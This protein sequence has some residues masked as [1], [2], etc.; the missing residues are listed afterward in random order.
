MAVRVQCMSCSA[1]LKAPEHLIGTTVACPKCKQQVQVVAAAAQGQ[2]NPANALD[3]LAALASQNPNVAPAGSPNLGFPQ[4]PG[5]PGVGAS[6]GG[7]SQPRK[8]KS[9]KGLWIALGSV[10]AV[11]IVAVVVVAL[12]PS[13]EDDTPR[14]E[15]AAN[16]ADE[17]GFR[18]GDVVSFLDGVTPVRGVYEYSVSGHLARI[19]FFDH[20]RNSEVARDV[21]KSLLTHALDTEIPDGISM[22]FLTMPMGGPFVPDRLQ[23]VNLSEPIYVRVPT[24]HREID[25]SGYARLFLSSDRSIATVTHKD[26]SLG[27]SDDGVSIFSYRFQENQQVAA[28]ELTKSEGY[29][30]GFLSD[31]TTVLCSTRNGILQSILRD[32]ELLR[33]AEQVL[34]YQTSLFG[35]IVNDQTLYFGETHRLLYLLDFANQRIPYKDGKIIGPAFSANRKYMAIR[36]KDREGVIGADV[37]LPILIIDCQKM[38]LAAVIEYEDG[39]HWMAFSDDGTKLAG[40][41][42]NKVIVFDLLSCEVIKTIRCPALAQKIVWSG[43]NYL[44]LMHGIGLADNQSVKKYT[45]I[46]IAREAPI[47]QWNDTETV[48]FFDIASLGNGQFLRVVNLISTNLPYR[49]TDLVL[50][51]LQLPDPSWD[52]EGPVGVHLGDAKWDI[53]EV[54]LSIQPNN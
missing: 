17:L 22:P 18:I 27:L 36:Q 25:R 14:A 8:K 48:R 4:A 51:S 41:Y 53:P 24:E 47:A 13:S 37:A 35:G 23:P 12:L 32:G 43:D 11:L 42:Y 29:P 39:I 44:L 31:D 45:L 40:L 5:S 10:T 2:S 26:D 46:D 21:D 52:L 38:E 3:D 49:T 50:H 16:E 30:I 19:R 33:Q 7:Y 15:V 6:F 34:P 9:Q 54:H 1:M 28:V 20:E